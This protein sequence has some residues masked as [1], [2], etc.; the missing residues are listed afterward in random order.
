MLPVL[1][2]IFTDILIRRLT[3]W[4][5]L[6][7][8]LAH[9]QGGFRKEHST[10]DSIFCL[11][12]LV[13]KSLRKSTGRFYVAF[14]DFE[15]A[16][17]RIN[18]QAPF[19][20]LFSQNIST[21][22]TNI[23]K[24]IYSDVKARVKSSKGCSESF[25][26]PFGVRQGC[27]LSPLLFS[28]FLND[29]KDFISEGSHGVDLDMHTL[30]VL[31]YADDLAIVAE[32]R[33]EL[34]RLLDKLRL[35]CQKWKMR[36]NTDKTKIIVFR[37]GGYL[38]A[39]EK[40]FFGTYQLEVVTYFKYLGLVFSSRLS[41]YMCQKTIAAQASKAVFALKSSLANY[42]HVSTDILFKIFDSKIQPILT[43]GAE[44]W[45]PH[46]ANDIEIVHTKF[47]KY[48]LKLPWQASNAFVRG[49]LGRFKLNCYYIL[50]PIRY[51]LRLLE[52]SDTRMHK[53][54]YKCQYKWAENG[55]TCWALHIKNILFQSGFGYAWLNQGVGNKTMFLSEF[56]QKFKDVSL[57]IWNE[58]IRES[59]R[60]SNYRLVKINFGIEPYINSIDNLY[61]RS[62]L[63]RFRG[64]ILPLLCNKG[65]YYSIP[66]AQRICPLCKLDVETEY[67]FLLICP[68]LST[69]R[70]KLL[71]RYLY[72]NPS[73]IKYIIFVS[74]SRQSLNF[75]LANYI[76]HALKLREAVM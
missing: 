27:S 74:S 28:L 8:K 37:N 31:L 23:I 12:T 71:P 40:W 58:E 45:F 38:R 73:E 42:T 19:Q 15:K 29:V 39:Y 66:W 56:R 9:E 50:K 70:E 18:I 57:Q 11:S 5:D 26:C 20:T 21:K 54:F 35:Y 32:T 67:H 72:E 55:D 69:I 2:K 44:L 62:L 59:S 6:N 3:K 43:Y 4:C 22:M 10:I 64:G 34:Q 48:V 60:L 75:A 68:K 13:T 41:W 46:N 24:S 14:V 33:I 49:E 65:V 7:D 16:F 47:C 52:M 76:K 1:S 36:V 53:Q 61:S 30:F 63:L 25:E 17:D 51:W